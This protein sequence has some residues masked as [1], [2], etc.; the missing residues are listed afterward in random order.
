MFLAIDAVFHMHVVEGKN[1]VRPQQLG[2]APED[3]LQ[4]AAAEHRVE[5]FDTPGGCDCGCYT[6]SEH[7]ERHIRLLESQACSNSLYTNKNS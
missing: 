3:G 2:E 7:R 5:R 4:A 1:T 6:S